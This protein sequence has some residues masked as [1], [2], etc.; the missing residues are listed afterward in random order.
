MSI[1]QILYNVEQ[2]IQTTESK[3]YLPSDL[4]EITQYH[5]TLKFQNGLRTHILNH[6]KSLTLLKTPI[7]VFHPDSLKNYFNHHVSMDILSN[8]RFL[9]GF[10]IHTLEEL[11]TWYL[12]INPK[13]YKEYQNYG[14]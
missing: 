12:S 5:T 6:S 8:I 13:E 4:Y 1:F 3:N 7:Q 10:V 2:I 9:N 14:R 11:I